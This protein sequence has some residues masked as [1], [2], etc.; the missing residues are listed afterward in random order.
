MD[1]MARPDQI[2]TDSWVNA[3]RGVGRLAFKSPDCTTR[4]VE[5]TQLLLVSD[6]MYDGVP[7]GSIATLFGEPF[8]KFLVGNKHTAP[9]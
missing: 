7:K 5:L 8:T 1:K 2:F 9:G 6:T 3:A 4:Q